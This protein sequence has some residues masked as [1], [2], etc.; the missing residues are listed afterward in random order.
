MA[1]TTSHRRHFLDKPAREKTAGLLQSCLVD[2]I[3]LGLQG[4]QAHWNLVGRRFR[5]VHRQLDEIVE[6]ARKASDEVAERIVAIDAGAD[7][8]PSTLVSDSSLEPFPD[9]RPHV[10]QVVTLI[11]D[12]LAAVVATLRKG[13]D[14]LEDADAVSQNML[15]DICQEMEKHLWMVQ[16]QEEE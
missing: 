2:L 16:V 15:Q 9:G 11:A 5:E 10:E 1:V 13:I 6:S 8:R 7:G 4:K 14:G 12:R 3:D